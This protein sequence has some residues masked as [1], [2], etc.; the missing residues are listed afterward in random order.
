VE[1][2]HQE[3]QAV[4]KLGLQPTEDVPGASF[5]GTDADREIRGQ[6]RPE[7]EDPRRPKEK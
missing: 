4:E 5:A 3:A 1:A 7:T 6:C 2:L